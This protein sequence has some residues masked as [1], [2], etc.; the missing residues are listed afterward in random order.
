M[1]TQ[2]T[3]LKNKWQVLRSLLIFCV[4]TVLNLYNLSYA[5]NNDL[6]LNGAYIILDGGTTATPI[7]LVVAQSSTSGIIRP[8]GGH[9]SSEGQYNFVKWTS[10]AS[11]G[12]YIFPF[13]VGG[14]AVDYIPFTFNKT[15]A[16]NSDIGMSTWTT[17]PQNMPHPAISN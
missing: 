13:G 3:A 9:I 10:A 14:N 4:I 16:G 2:I 1:Q 5:Q 6:V 17:N 11:T 8:G 7:Y 15:S 12:N